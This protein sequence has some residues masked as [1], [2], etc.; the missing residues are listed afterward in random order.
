[1]ACEGEVGGGS[2]EAVDE[3]DLAFG[4]F[5]ADVDTVG[6]ADEFSVLEL[7]AGALVAVVEQDVDACGFEIGG[8]LFAGGEQRLLADVGDG[9]DDLIRRDGGRQSVL[10]AGCSCQGTAT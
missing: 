4:E 1:M 5:L 2:G 6:D 7:D 9:D 8:D 3:F 10:L